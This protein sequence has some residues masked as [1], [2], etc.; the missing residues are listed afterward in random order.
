[1]TTKRTSNPAPV[2]PKRIGGGGG[3][4]TGRGVGRGGSSSGK[5][6]PVKK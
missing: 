1:M 4:R 5:G 3:N 6:R 2:L